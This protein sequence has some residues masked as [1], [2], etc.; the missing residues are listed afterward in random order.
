MVNRPV[1]RQEQAWQR[2]IEFYLKKESEGTWTS[3]SKK[4]LPWVKVP[5]G[6]MAR[7]CTDHRNRYF[8]LGVDV[9]HP[10]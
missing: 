7:K 3:L 10:A 1:V 2:L 8:C 9:S 5:T 4:K 6:Q